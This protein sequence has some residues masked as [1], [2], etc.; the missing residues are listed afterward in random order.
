LD[1]NVFDPSDCVGAFGDGAELFGSLVGALQRQELGFSRTFGS[2]S[3]YTTAI[4]ELFHVE[5]S[6][7]S[8]CEGCERIHNVTAIGP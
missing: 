2:V 7:Q 1:L 8:F 3:K 6:V 4:E 5:S